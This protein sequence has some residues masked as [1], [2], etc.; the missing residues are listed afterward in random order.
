MSATYRGHPCADTWDKMPV[1]SR[2]DCTQVD[3]TELWVATFS[4]SNN[5]TTMD[6][7]FSLNLDQENGVNI[8]FNACKRVLRKIMIW[9]R[10]IIGCSMR[11]GRVLK[12]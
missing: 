7:S 3:V 11:A 2:S 1:V 5:D 12:S 8:K 6:A 10:I 4:P 9:D